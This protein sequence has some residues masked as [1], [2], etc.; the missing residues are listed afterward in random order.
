MSSTPEVWKLAE[1]RAKTDR[2]L[3]RIVSEA[4]EHGLVLARM[5]STHYV[6]GERLQADG[7]RAKA[8]RAYQESG[9]LAPVLRGVGQHQRTRLE[10]Q[11]RELRDTLDRLY[12]RRAP[13]KQTAC[14]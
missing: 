3:L 1:L 2:Q 4:L 5:A 13:L 11:R 14:C 8:E 6:V 12:E 9:M 7:L 10:Q